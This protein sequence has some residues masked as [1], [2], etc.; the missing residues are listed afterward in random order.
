[1]IPKVTDGDTQSSEEVGYR[2]IL[3]KFVEERTERRYAR[4]GTP[5]SECTLSGGED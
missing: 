3:A 1:M 5:D 4:D 2:C